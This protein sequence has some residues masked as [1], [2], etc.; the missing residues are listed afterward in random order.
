MTHLEAVTY[1]VFVVYMLSF[2][3]ASL[4]AARAS[5]RTVW[6]FDKGSGGQRLTALLFRLGFVGGAVWP[7]CVA[8]GL[9]PLR[10]DPIRSRLDTLPAD[11]AGH[12]LVTIGA[13]IAM[14]SQLH[15]G[16]SW[17]IGA[18]KGE[19]GPIIDGGPFAISRN[20]VFVGQGL[21]FVGLLF[22]FPGIVQAILT[23]AVLL[24]IR[25]QVAI[26]ETALLASLGEPYR[27]YMSRVRR[28]VGT[29]SASRQN[30]KRSP[31]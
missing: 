12:L 23:L 15:M 21:L 7:I 20:P 6:L 5:G 13:S 17:R 8:L 28:W 24:A 10:D 2:I 14:I 11:L 26:E 29:R 25:V 30:M 18:V 31:S 27:I 4:M 3:A 16:Q 19:L 1:L 9:D 22:V